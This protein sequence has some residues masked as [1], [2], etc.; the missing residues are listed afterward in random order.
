V[1]LSLP[2]QPA[3]VQLLSAR[4]KP[5]WSVFVLRSFDLYNGFV[6]QCHTGNLS[7]QREWYRLFRSCSWHRCS[8]FRDFILQLQFKIFWSTASPNNK[9]ITI[10]DSCRCD[11][12]YQTS[13]FNAPISRIT[14]P[15]TECF[16]LNIG[17]NPSSDCSWSALP[18]PLSVDGF[19][20]FYN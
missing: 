10:K 19:W 7:G 20:N 2:D 3:H 4:D 15:V 5:A 6:R 12:T 18:A 11:L 16:P 14:F 17:I 9:C 1:S 8:R 13:I